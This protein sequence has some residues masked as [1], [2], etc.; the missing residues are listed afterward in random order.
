MRPSALRLA[1]RPIPLSSVPAG[2]LRL[3]PKPSTA[4]KA[5]ATHSPTVNRLLKSFANKRNGSIARSTGLSADGRGLGAA[6]PENVEQD[7]AQA[8][9][10][11]KVQL[12]ANLRIEQFL[13]KR[14][15]Y[16]GVK[17]GH[18]EL[19]SDYLDVLRA[20]PDLT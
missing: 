12:P 10:M 5:S 7:V 17:S 20:G 1:T 8:E 13:P 11:D 2:L 14:K 4:P 6:V 19:V 18:R 3:P 9:G 15:E 16:S